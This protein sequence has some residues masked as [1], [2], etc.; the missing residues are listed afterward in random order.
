ML[1]RLIAFS[2]RNRVVVVVAALA[3]AFYGT[4]VATS[5]PIDVLPDLNRPTVT[6]LTEAHGLVPEDVEQLVTRYIEQSVNGAT[7]V[8]RVRSASGLGLSVVFVE[9]DW[10]TDIY[11]N[12][13][14]VQEKLQLARAQLPPGVEPHM[15]PI[16][17]IMGQ[18]QLLGIRSKSGK[19]DPTAIRAFVD[20]TLK[21][22]LLSISGVAQVVSIG[23]AP[24]QLQVTVDAEKLIAYDVTLEEVADAIRASNASGSGGFLNI[25]PKGPLVT[26]TGLVRDAPQLAQAVVRSDAVRP[27][28]IGDVAEI[29]FGPA[30]IRTG[31]AGVNGSAGVVA[32]VFKQPDVDT[33]VLAARIE[34]ELQSVAQTLPADL[35]LLPALYRQSDFIERAI[36]NVTDAVRDGS[37]L[38]MLI[39]FA[40]LLNFRTTAITLTAI[41][42]SIA[43][44]A[45]VFRLFDISINTMTLGGLAVAIGAL[46]DDAIVD[47]E[48]VY[49]RL[50]ENRQA[51]SPKRPLAVIYLA[52]SEVRKPILIGTLVVAAV[53]LPL[54]ALSGMEGRLFAPI[55]VAYIVSIMASLLVSLTVTPVLCAWLL[56]KS[57]AV[58]RAE[59]GWLVRH[60]KSGAARMIEFS[61]DRP[62]A[63]S[64]V[65]AALVLGG[66][67]ILATRG[68]EFLPPF[69]EGTAQINLVLPPGTSLETSDRFGARLEKL[70]IDIDG[71]ASA[72]RRTGRAEGDEH[73]E[74]VN[75]SEVIVAFDE[76]TDRTREEILSEI[77]DRMAE[78]F[79]GVAT[80]AEQPL[81]H[82]LSHLLSGVTA[83][84]AIKIF[85]NDLTT[86]RRT[87]QKVET[88]LRPIPGVV[89][90]STEQQVLV[91]QIAVHPDRAALARHGLTVE[92]VTHTVELA[93]EGE[94]VSRLVLGQYS[95]PIVLRLEAE[96]R[97]DLTSV[98]QL[99]VPTGDGSRLRLADI[100]KVG[101]TRTPN[102]I[103]R[104]NVS[105]RIVVKHNVQGRALGEVVADVERA[106]GTIR[107]DLK[108]GYSI[109][110][111]G[112]FEAQEKAARV[113]SVLSLLSLGV[114]FLLIFGH[115]KSANLAIQTLLN[116]P[117]AFVGA[118]AFILLTDQ[119]ISIATLVGLISLG[120]IAARNKILLLDHYLHLM[121]E[122]G[123]AF[124]RAM[125]VR[126]GKERIVP[127]LMTAL[128]SGI[129]LVP[130][131]LSPGQPGRE[132]L[133]PVASVIVGG[134]VSTTLLDVLLTPG[135]FWTFGR[136]AAESA[137]AHQ[138][139]ESKIP[140]EFL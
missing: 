17:S 63:I 4:F 56:P 46:V 35:E 109:R 28:R 53:Y 45:L 75:M 121:K 18:I 22:R 101:L 14:I 90:L 39:L 26:V 87:A 3:V 30:A 88:A 117:M 86:L 23:G 25:G 114:M 79:P 133:Y 128:T 112:Q 126:A 99:L 136:Q 60:L 78:M 10:E 34:K 124:S 21:L 59:D 5:L 40:F 92:E 123:E 89:D 85:G 38:V 69:N 127:V 16:A 71:V 48:N 76:D 83:Q 27:V 108:P 62:L 66:V 140:E 47:V 129:A 2:L 132:L 49:R 80:S 115:F 1:N 119:T 52:S 131:V 54:F 41:P 20:Q 13:Q 120:G 93:M 96:D 103:N 104:E 107:A 97:K 42:L 6:I 55:G 139:A 50:R 61:M 95:Y 24:K 51:E 100:A 29:K 7:G 57:K 73:A 105:R 9:F 137:A 77:R 118:V 134:L 72:A 110:V 37:I 12:R 64:T 67:W 82:L 94:E 74:G 65:L 111:S 70:C 32:V 116:I 84:V 43:T 106:L 68:S 31:D 81:A 135:L 98:R 15:A 130:L 36:D 125:I 102:N 8:A 11:R 33:T 91:A 19:T 138:E 122:E 113:V 58:D 44:T